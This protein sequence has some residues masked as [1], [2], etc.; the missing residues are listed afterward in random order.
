MAW[1]FAE[2]KKRSGITVNPIEAK[3]VGDTY[4]KFVAGVMAGDPP[5]VSFTSVVYGRDMYDQG[6]VAELDS[7]V[8]KAPDVQDDKYFAASKQFRQAA[9]TPSASRSRGRNRSAWVSTRTSLRPPAWIRRARTSRPG[10]IWC[11]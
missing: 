2:F 3:P 8:A 11:A 4:T 10:T 5:D 9:G 6:L 1:A 7:Y